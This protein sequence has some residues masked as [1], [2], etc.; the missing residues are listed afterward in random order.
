MAGLLSVD[1]AR[2]DLS[3]KGRVAIVTGA[4]RGLGE[5]IAIGF[6]HAGAEVVLAARTVDDL[7]RVAVKVR[8]HRPGAL[9]VSTDVTDSAQCN[10]LIERALGEFGKVDI[11]VNNA[12]DPV[13]RGAITE[14][15]DE[16]RDYLMRSHLYSTFYCCRAVASHMIGR[17]CGKIINMSSQMGLVGYPNRSAY[18][19]AK[20]GVIQM[21][22][23][24]AVELAPHQICVNALAPTHIETPHNTERVR[25]ES[26]VDEMLPRIPMGRFGRW[27]D[28]IGAAV[29]LAAPA[30]DLITGQTIAIDGGWTAI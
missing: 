7:E 30:S 28:V 8:E 9:V 16:R 17:R 3:L 21:T 15:T 14:L 23:A 13:A 10:V 5:A 27:E 18:A 12:G 6:A 20:G 4:S 1:F 24:L 2:A 19:A 29:F 26:F 25:E 11:L 22:R